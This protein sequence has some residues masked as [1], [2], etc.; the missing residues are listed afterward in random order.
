MTSDGAE[1]AELAASP[2]PQDR[3]RIA[4]DP[5]LSP[6]EVAAF[7]ANENDPN[8]LALWAQ[9]PQAAVVA[10]RLRSTGIP[11][12]VGFLDANPAVPTTAPPSGPPP[13]GPPSG[14]PPSGPPPNGAP[15]GWAPPPTLAGAVPELAADRLLPT[16]QQRPEQ[17]WQRTVWSVSG[18]LI[19]PKPGKVEQ[20]RKA[21]RAAIN[22]PLPVT[23][24][25]RVAIVSV[26]GGVGKTTTTLMLGHTFA[27]ERQDRTIALDANPDMGTLGLRV[28]DTAPASIRDL[29]EADPAPNTHHAVR[30]F[31]QL[32][33]TRLEVLASPPDPHVSEAITGD[34][35]RETL[36]RIEPFYS[37][38]LTD[39]GT[40][41]LHDTMGAILETCDQLVLVAG[42]AA[43]EARAAAAALPWF[44]SHGYA[45]LVS[46][47]VVVINSVQPKSKVDLGAINAHF[48]TRCRAVVSVPWDAALF[49]GGT[50]TV[51][52]LGSRTRDAYL[53][54]AAAVVAGWSARQH[55]Q[56]FQ[57]PS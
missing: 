4:A 25:V 6:E 47:A 54:L 3:A 28:P 20:R 14:P 12:V 51:D 46:N 22:A 15:E 30:A 48:S 33:P 53:E 16:R 18:G 42:A 29:L 55:H 11:A 19:K 36:R 39:T 44:D 35:Y 1:M 37:I 23:G 27:T 40:G 10:D 41:L 13:G 5:S 49:T 57:R 45:D 32:A 21:M 26:K 50:H 8:V 17:G 34:D 7:A 38:L 24:Q 2:H 56:Q 9:H 31:T 52:D 43:D